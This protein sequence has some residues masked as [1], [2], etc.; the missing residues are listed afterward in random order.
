MGRHLWVPSK[1]VGRPKL[2]LG[3][4]DRD[5]GCLQHPRND[6]ENG[7]TAASSPF[8]TGGFDPLVDHLSSPT[9]IPEVPLGPMSL[10][11]SKEDP[12]ADQD[13]GSPT[14]GPQRRITLS[15]SIVPSGDSAVFEESSFFTRNSQPLPSPAEVRAET[16]R[17]HPGNPRNRNNPLPVHYPHLGLTVKYE[18]RAV[19][20]EGQCL[21]VIRHFF[22]STV[23]VPEVY[24]WTTDQGA[25]FI[26]M[27]YIP[28]ETLEARWDQLSEP[29][30]LDICGQLRSMVGRIRTLEQVPGDRFI[31]RRPRR[32]LDIRTHVS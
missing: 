26:Y 15:P 8:S 22:G 2:H 21:W 20:A 25:A 13:V 7:Q 27:E 30:R 9:V 28:G 17:R 6:C 32:W 24:G 3:G 18:G 1:A 31:G 10:A 11:A 4:S 29:E 12:P 16:E 14:I 19:T 23:P 5:V